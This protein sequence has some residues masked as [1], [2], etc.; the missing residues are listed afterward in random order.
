MLIAS[1]ITIAVAP[2]NT[3]YKSLIPSY[4][5]SLSLFIHRIFIAKKCIAWRE[6]QMCSFRIVV[7]ISIF[8]VSCQHIH[9]HTMTWLFIQRFFCCCCCFNL[10]GFGLLLLYADDMHTISSVNEL[11]SEATFVT[12]THT[13][14]HVS[15]HLYSENYMFLNGYVRMTATLVPMRHT[16]HKLS[17]YGLIEK[18]RDECEWA[19]WRI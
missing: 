11:S 19:R 15:T 7:R 18:I 16:L 4:S 14:T 9:A 10:L 13:R 1:A 5:F 2:R 12:Y 8:N 3:K 17:I 6:K